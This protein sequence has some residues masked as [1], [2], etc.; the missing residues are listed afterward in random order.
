MKKRLQTGIFTALG[1]G[2]ACA[3]TQLWL[4]STGYDETGLLKADHPAIWLGYALAAAGLGLTVFAVL[5]LNPKPRYGKLFPGSLWAAAGAFAA[6]LGLIVMGWQQLAAAADTLSR[7]CGI[8]ALIAAAAMGVNGYFR[9]QGRQP[10]FAL[11]AVNCLFFMVALYSRYQNWNIETQNSVFFFPLLA[12]ILSMLACYYR[13]ALDSG[14]GSVRLWLVF[15]LTALFFC[16]GS[17]FSRS[18]PA[19]MLGFCCYFLG[20]LTAVRLPKGTK[21]APNRERAP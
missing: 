2:L 7:V 15:S 8:A 4:L 6:V 11:L 21:A 16:C 12:L 14:N 19:L 3:L 13:S 18:D 5:P 10:H 1:V 17:L 9:L 20:E